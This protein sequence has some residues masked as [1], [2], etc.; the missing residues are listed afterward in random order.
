MWDLPRP[1]IEPMFPALAGR[2]LTTVSPGKS[3]W[4]LFKI[5]IS[6]WVISIEM[7]SLLLLF[8]R[9]VLSHQP[10][11][12]FFTSDIAFLFLE[13][14]FLSCSFHVSAKILHLFLDC[15]LLFHVSL[16]HINHSHFKV[17]LIVPISGSSL[18][19]VL[20]VALSW[21]QVVFPWFFECLIILIGCWLLL[22]EEQ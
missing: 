22:V 19:L 1:G 20:L 17:C 6:L 14:L 18:C 10:I 15:I 5:T 3:T 9:C 2:F 4:T 11:K 16:L 8:F 12:E 13:F 21:Q 7:L